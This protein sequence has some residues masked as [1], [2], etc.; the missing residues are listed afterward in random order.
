MLATL[1]A[2]AW[3]MLTLSALNLV[4]LATILWAVLRLNTESG[5]NAEDSS[6]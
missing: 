2:W 1:T 5:T 3:G 6:R 4:L